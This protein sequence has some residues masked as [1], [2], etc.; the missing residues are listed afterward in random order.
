MYEARKI[1]NL[2]L[3]NFNASA[4]GITNLRLNKLLYFVHGHALLERPKGLVR[5]HFEAWQHGPVVRVVYDAFKQ[6]EERTIAS[7]ATFLDYSSGQTRPVPFDDVESR[8]AAFVCKICS[9]YTHYSTR[10]LVALSHEPGGA[11][12]TVYKSLD[13]NRRTNS[14][15]SDELIRRDFL[16][17]PVGKIR[18]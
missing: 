3:A 11:W 1:C 12:D 14:R 4:F 10:A 15:I 8:D 13:L 6:F 17:D 16:N 2:I 7:P 9:I 18:H 5:N